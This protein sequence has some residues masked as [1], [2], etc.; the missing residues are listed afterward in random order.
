MKIDGKKLI[1]G[2]VGWAK[3]YGLKGIERPIGGGRFNKENIGSEHQNFAR[4]E[5][6]NCYGYIRTQSYS[7]GFDMKLFDDK[8]KKQMDGF[9]VILF[10]NNPYRGKLYVI[11]W[12]KNA[13]IL[14]KQQKRPAPLDDYY[15]FYANEESCILIPQDNRIYQITNELHGISVSSNMAY[16]VNK[17]EL[18]PNKGIP[19]VIKYVENYTG[20]NWIEDSTEKKHFYFSGRKF[21]AEDDKIIYRQAEI[22]FSPKPAKAISYL[23]DQNTKVYFDNNSHITLVDG[24]KKL[25]SDAKLKRVSLLVFNINQHFFKMTEFHTLFESENRVDCRILIAPPAGTTRKF[26]ETLFNWHND[27]KLEARQFKRNMY[28]PYLMHTKLAIFEMED[29]NYFASVGSSN[30]TLGGTVNNIEYNVFFNVKEH[31]IGKN[32][33]LEYFNTFWQQADELNPTDFDDAPSTTI[34]TEEFASE[35]AVTVAE[36]EI[37]SKKLFN[38]QIT[39]IENLSEKINPLLRTKAQKGGPENSGCFLIM[40]T[41]SGKTYTMVK[42]LFD[43]VFNNDGK[44]KKVLWLAHRKELLN[45]AY[46]TAYIQK[47]L[48]DNE[49]TINNVHQMVS[50]GIYFEKYF[51]DNLIFL[52]SQTAYRKYCANLHKKSRKKLKVAEKKEIERIR[53]EML[54]IRESTKFDLIIID[55]AHRASSETLQYGNI[56]KNL[57]YKAVC[58]ITATP[59]RGDQQ[60]E[61]LQSKFKNSV[62]TNIEDIKKDQ[63]DL[64]SELQI[65]NIS[66]GFTLKIDGENNLRF[67]NS[68][69]SAK[70]NKKRNQIIVDEYFLHSSKFNQAIIFCIDCEHANEIA[71]MINERLNEAQTFHNGI[72]DEQSWAKRVKNDL[73]IDENQKSI[74]PVRNEVIDMFRSGKIKTLTSVFLLTEGFDVPNVDAI[75]ITRPTLST[76]LYTQMLGRGMRG[77]A[78]GGTKSCLVFDFEDQLEYHTK[79]HKR[80]INMSSLKPKQKSVHGAD[81]L[82]I[83]TESLLNIKEINDLDMERDSLLNI[84]TKPKQEEE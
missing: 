64:F 22:P 32:S 41:G 77:P 60:D 69:I 35:P 44:N 74:E 14:K 71:R 72:I 82:A 68:L 16:S 49:I 53:D 43:N 66:T 65:F 6:G 27:K 21:Q 28:E 76:L 59:Y 36:P 30:F 29:Q 33:P 50:S 75:F 4:H 58:G 83:E 55:E 67:N 42:W 34:P 9:T 79:T 13:S 81:I 12:Y 63:M 19:E 57:Y 38:Y 62:Q 54:Q 5:N 11:G 31:A 20:Q 52:T 70:N 17:G 2:R 78:V 23:T 61:T 15:N 24:F 84:D 10:S 26:A 37:L 56:L 8:P 45:Q 3:Y 48:T 80:L 25:L 18:K 51:E 7:R 47:L 1:F 40:P 46:D 39:A 73:F